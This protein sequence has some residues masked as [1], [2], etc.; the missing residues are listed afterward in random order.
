MTTTQTIT[1]V[2]VEMLIKMET[3]YHLWCY[4]G[5]ISWRR[6]NW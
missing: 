1:Q 4:F 5:W 6:S 3:E 2:Y